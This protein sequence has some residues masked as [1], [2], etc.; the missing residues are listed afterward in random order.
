MRGVAP[1]SNFSD[2]AGC[3]ELVCW[4]MFASS[5]ASCNPTNTPNTEGQA[6]HTTAN[7]IQCDEASL[8]AKTQLTTGV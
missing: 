5:Q 4:L 6:H 1:A 2:V 8:N 3:M 7:K